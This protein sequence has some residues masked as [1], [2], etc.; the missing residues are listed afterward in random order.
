[1]MRPASTLLWLLLG[2]TALGVLA[3]IGWLPLAAWLAFAALVIVVGALDA[4]NLRAEPSPVL[5]R[6]LPPVVP[7]GPELV[8]WLRLRPQGK[9][10]LAF[11]LHDLHPGC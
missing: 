7:L 2:W 4:R 9:R 10:E 3:A 1:M 8:V 11:E 6:E 5:G